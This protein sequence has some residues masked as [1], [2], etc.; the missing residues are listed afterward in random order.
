MVLGVYAVSAYRSHEE[1]LE[2]WRRYT[3]GPWVTGKLSDLLGD[4]QVSE[5]PWTREEMEAVDKVELLEKKLAL[6][7][8]RMQRIEKLMRERGNE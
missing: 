4:E 3:I 5:W 8:S 2:Q 7:L 1:R 6:V